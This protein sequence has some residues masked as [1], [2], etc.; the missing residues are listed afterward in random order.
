MAGGDACIL[1]WPLFADLGSSYKARA[2]A[3]TQARALVGVS[4]LVESRSGR[5][6]RRRRQVW[7][8]AVGAG[9][10]CWLWQSG[11][12]RDASLTESGR[13]VQADEK[14]AGRAGLR[15]PGA[16]SRPA[17]AQAR[18]GA[19]SRLRSQLRAACLGWARGQAMKDGPMAAVSAGRA[20]GRKLSAEGGLARGSIRCQR[21]AGPCRSLE[22]GRGSSVRGPVKTL[23][24]PAP[25]APCHLTP[26]PLLG[27][28]WCKPFVLQG[29]TGLC[30]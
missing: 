14:R 2:R 23:E 16:G 27:C 20:A 1:L 18:N 7:T 29:R 28:P 6:L 24:E 8:G 10:S 12:R 19:L 22:T 11:P 5:K 15:L 4:G 13:A 30:G 26:G 21:T 3:E 9:R 25:T 17:D